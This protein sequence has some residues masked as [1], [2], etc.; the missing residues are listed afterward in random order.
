MSAVLA[1]GRAELTKLVTLRVVWLVTAVILGLHVLIMIQNRDLYADAVANITADGVI[2]IFTGQ[3]QPAGPAVLD[4]LAGASLQ[5]TLFLPILAVVTAG[6]EF[7]SHQLGSSVLAVP[8]R[9]RLMLAKTL[10]AATYLLF[11]AVLIAAVSTYFT[12]D[13]IR[14]WRPGLLLTGPALLTNAKFLLYAVLFSV[15]CQAFTVIGRSTLTGVMITMAL[16]AVTMTQVFGVFA[17]A[18]DALFPLSAGRNLLLDPK[19]NDLSAGP[20]QAVLVLIGWAL[21]SSVA[22]GVS[23]SR[24]DAR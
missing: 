11:V 4:M 16:I 5:M 1:A 13:A 20:S 12:Y 14:V 18:V 7:R 8:Q 17:P 21:V 24:R 22:A 10:A 9:G 23:L 3:P 6:Q 19:M 2:E 15:A